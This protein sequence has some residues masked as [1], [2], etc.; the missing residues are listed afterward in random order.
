MSRGPGKFQRAAIAVIRRRGKPTTFAEMMWEDE[1]KDDHDDRP[2][3]SFVRS[4]RR[5]IHKLVEGGVLVAIGDGGPADPFR[6]FFSPM[7]VGMIAEDKAER[8]ALY[9]ALMADPGA[10]AAALK[11]MRKMFPA[12]YRG[13]AG[14]TSTK[15][16]ATMRACT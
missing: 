12:G 1:D 6:Y 8:D 7:L 16:T 2:P 14:K 5:A 11:H 10:E 4:V 3:P 13:A 15:S 9:N